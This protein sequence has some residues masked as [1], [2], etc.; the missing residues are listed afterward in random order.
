[1]RKIRIETWK[2]RVPVRDSE[3]KIT[4]SEEQDENLLSAFNVLIANKKPDEMPRGIDKFRTFSR[5]SKA[6]DKA[7]KSKVLIL[8]ETD[9]KFLKDELEKN[10]PSTWGMNENLMKAVEAFLES[11][12][13]EPTK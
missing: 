9:Y 12:S 4:G 7:D 8:E 1:M 2:A 11:K 13:E 5:L 6:F 10:V 3:G